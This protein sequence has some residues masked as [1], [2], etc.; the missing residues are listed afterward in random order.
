MAWKLIS[1]LA[2]TVGFFALVFW[3]YLPRN[4][5]RLDSYGYIPLEPDSIASAEQGTT[6]DRT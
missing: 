5:E 1:M 6:E 2:V 4:K 3:V